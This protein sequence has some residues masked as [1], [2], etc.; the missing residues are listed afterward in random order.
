MKYFGTDEST[1]NMILCQ[2][3]YPHL[4]AVFHFYEQIVGHSIEEAIKSEF[5]GDIKNGLLAIGKNY[6]FL[7]TNNGNN[8]N[9][10]YDM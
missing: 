6:Q 8:I 4:R 3:S 1:F 2:R 10:I 5:S 7:I 9:I